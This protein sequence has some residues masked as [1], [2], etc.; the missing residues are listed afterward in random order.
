MDFYKLENGVAKFLKPRE[1]VGSKGEE[2][3]QKIIEKNIKEIFGLKFIASQTMLQGKR[4]DTL[5]YDEENDRI[6]VI[7]Y[8][9]GKDSGVVD[10]GITYLSL[11]HENKEFFEL[12]IEKKLGKSNLDIDWQS[13]RVFFIAHEFDDYQVSASAIRGVPFELW[14]YDIYDGFIALRKIEQTAT[15]T[16]FNTLVQTKNS[17]FEKIS[18]EIKTYDLDYHLNKTKPEFRPIFE[19]YSRTIKSFGPEVTEVIDQKAGITYKNNKTSFIRIE[20]EPGYLK[21]IFKEKKGFVD[22]KKLSQDIRGYKWGYERRVKVSSMHNFDDVMYLLKQAYE[23][24][25]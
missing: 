8:K 7:E 20:F 19:S 5:A 16:A 17:E 15:R 23:K 25:L 13:T 12:K 11:V 14:A 9:R 2:E 21:V 10:Q 1:L 24:T 4:F 22:P 18:K 6:V 3:L